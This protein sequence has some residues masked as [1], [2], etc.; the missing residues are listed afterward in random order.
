MLE[1]HFGSFIKGFDKNNIKLGIWSGKIDIENVSLKPEA[2]EMLQL[3]IKL[4]NS[5][6][7][8]M[9][10]NIPWSKLSRYTN[11]LIK[12]SNRGPD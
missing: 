3:P 11:N 5:K 12:R 6:I 1:N 4:R 7:G 9:H 2:I 10:F 8:K